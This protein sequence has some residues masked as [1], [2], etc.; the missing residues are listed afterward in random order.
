MV[1]PQSFNFE[2]HLCEVV[3]VTDLVH[4]SPLLCYLLGKSRLTFSSVSL[5]RVYEN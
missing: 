3:V 2:P 1:D 4:S 5:Y